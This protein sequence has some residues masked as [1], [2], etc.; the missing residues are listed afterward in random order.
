MKGF[1]LL[2]VLLSIATVSIIAGIGIPIYQSLQVRNDLDI[3]AITI[4]Q[5]FRRAQI[6]SQ[7]MDNDTNWGVRVQSGSITLFQG[8]S[9][10]GRDANFDELFDVP[11]S[12]TPSGVQEVVFTKFSGE[13]QTIGTVILTTNTNETRSI[14]INAKGMVSY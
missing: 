2:E 12:I 8:T 13:P 7:A 1:T 4:A 10:A 11:T 3:A 6:L 14:T 5:N 9:Y